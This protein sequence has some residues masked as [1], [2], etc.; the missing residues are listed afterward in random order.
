MY[1]GI[2]RDVEWRILMG[3]KIPEN[4]LEI[5]DYI[6]YSLDLFL[7]AHQKV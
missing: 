4:D 5:F 1:F 3:L 6:Q 7:K 2:L